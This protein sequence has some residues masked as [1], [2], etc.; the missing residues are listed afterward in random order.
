M[1]IPGVLARRCM[2]LALVALFTTAAWQGAK[3]PVGTFGATDP[4]GNVID[5]TFDT[6][7]VITAYVNDEAF[8]RMT[9]T[10]RGEEFGVLESSAPADYSCSD[11]K[12]TYKWKLDN[13]HLIFTI[14]TDTCEV[15]ARYFTG[16]TW[17]RR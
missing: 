1:K 7:G 17:V 5:L 13:D 15:R 16:L 3:F 12:G 14:V 9:Y 4:D 6:A 10:V 11:L 8:A 2:P